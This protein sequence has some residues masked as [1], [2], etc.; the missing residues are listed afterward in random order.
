MLFRECFGFTDQFLETLSED[1]YQ[2][3]GNESVAVSRRLGWQTNRTD[4]SVFTIGLHSRHIDSNH[5]GSSVQNEIE[6][7]DLC[8]DHFFKTRE[9]D[10][11]PC[12]VYIMSDRPMAIENLRTYLLPRKCSVV[13]AGQMID[14]EVNHDT[15]NK[16]KEH[17]PFA[18][19]GFFRDL[20]VVS[21]ARS[22]LIGGIRSSSAL[23]DELMDYGRHTEAWH[24]K[25][26]VDSLPRCHIGNRPDL[27]N[28]P[29][30]SA[31]KDKVQRKKSVK[32]FFGLRHTP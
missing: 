12:T 25:N 15:G 5:N 26:V 29:V 13:V 24:S 6:C 23:I 3:S 20:V 18:G 4:P 9:N 27:G 19:A 30:I 2:Q 7:L 16:T 17:G 28:R 10:K 31:W 32:E 22:V 11:V 14:P 21:Q 8:L 1:W